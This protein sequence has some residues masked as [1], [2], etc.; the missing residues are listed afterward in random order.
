MNPG[1]SRLVPS[2]AVALAF[3]GLAV[4]LGGCFGPDLAS[5]PLVASEPGAAPPTPERVAAV[6]EIRA[7]GDAADNLP[8]PDAF[9][10]EQTARLAVRPE[11][12]PASD[13]AGIEAELAAIALLQE[14]ASTAEER[15]ELQARAD[16]LRRKAAE[17][18]AGR[19]RP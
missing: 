15:A 17:D 6:A 16:A 5:Q 18:Q 10:A 8:Y 12:R 9:Q 2:F 7:K 13:V 11:P 4:P 14:N 3:G 19:V 1:R